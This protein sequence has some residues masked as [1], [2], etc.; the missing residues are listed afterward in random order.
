[1]ITRKLSK[2]QG[3]IVTG[4]VSNLA[5]LQA[6]ANEEQGALAAYA[7]MAR[8]CFGLP[9]GEAQFSQGPDGWS[10]IVKPAPI[11]PQPEAG[12]DVEEVGAKPEAGPD[13]EPPPSIAEA[14]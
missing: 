5:Q 13:D 3:Y 2:E 9:E 7:E 14:A 10:I 1:M 4:L 11:A 8:S 12:A 6:K